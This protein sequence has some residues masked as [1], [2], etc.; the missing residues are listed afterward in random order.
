[1]RCAR[2]LFGQR[3]AVVTP[4]DYLT[5]AINTTRGRAL[6]ALLDYGYWVRR[7][8]G[9][10]AEV[11]EVFEILERRF[12]GSP[13]LTYPERALLGGNF[14]RIYG[15][16]SLWV[17]KNV[18]NLFDQSDG[19]GWQIA[20]GTYL[21]FNRAHSVLFD[22]LQ[23]QFEFALDRLRL[24][25]S[26]TRRRPDPV[27]HLGEHLLDYFL[28][29]RIP[30]EGKDS[31]LQ[32][33]YNKTDSKQWATLFDHLGRLLR[34]TPEL[35]DEVRDRC[36]AFFESRLRA[37]NSEE[38]KEF[39]FWM[40]AKCLDVAWRLNALSRTLDVTKG[41]NR[42][43]S[44]L[45]ESLGKLLPAHPD[46]VVGCFAK[47]IEGALS[48]PHFY[49][50]PEHIKPILKTGLA[51]RNENTAEAAKFALDN[52]LKAGRSEFLNLDAIKDDAK[53]N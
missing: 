53:W 10:K 25:K 35:S 19:E 28:L 42:S 37:E 5:D 3:C 18:S 1:M 27:A 13:A 29:G 44:T 16:N 6:E 26:E 30:L 17:R 32:R 48:Q 47:L 36:K 31:L 51:S 41:R 7:N 11:P 33:F 40:E 15:L 24:W 2:F 23:S 22:V 34:N 43:A 50:R 21:N 14:N 8:E 20:F 52:L 49:I 12:S 4:R 38:L 39:T 45:I 9:E 46:L